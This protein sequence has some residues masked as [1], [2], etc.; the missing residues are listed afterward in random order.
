[1][2][3]VVVGRIWREVF[4]EAMLHLASQGNPAAPKLVRDRLKLSGLSTE[5]LQVLEEMLLEK[6]KGCARKRNAGASIN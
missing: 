1:M 6:V 4:A 5:E 3:T 2:P